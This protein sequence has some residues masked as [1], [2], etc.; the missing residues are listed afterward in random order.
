M[1]WSTL[2][3]VTKIGFC[4]QPVCHVEQLESGFDARQVAFFSCGFAPRSVY[5]RARNKQ[6]AF[7]LLSSVRETFKETG[8]MEKILTT[9]C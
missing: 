9:Q 6:S 7:D 2:L 8:Q 5:L 3:T 4:H 1:R